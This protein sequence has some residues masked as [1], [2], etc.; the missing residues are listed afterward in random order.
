MFGTQAILNGNDLTEVQEM[1]GHRNIVTTRGYVHLAGKDAHMFGAV[2]KAVGR[3]K[4]K[5]DE[6]AK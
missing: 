1:M 6:P 2:E 4:P 5:P 3:R